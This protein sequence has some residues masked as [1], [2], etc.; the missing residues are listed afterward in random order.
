[1]NSK[2]IFARLLANENITIIHGNGEYAMFNTN[3]RVLTLPLWNDME[4]YDLLLGHEVGHALYTPANAWY[5]ALTTN[6]TVPKDIFNIVEDVRIERLIQDKYPGLVSSFKRGYKHMMSKDMFRLAGETHLTVQKYSFLDRMNIKAK[7]RDLVTVD[8]L[9]EELVFVERAN[10][11]ETFDEVIELSKDI[12]EHVKLV[13]QKIAVEAVKEMEENSRAEILEQSD[14]EDG[15]QETLSSGN[16]SAGEM[17]V[18]QPAE[19]SEDNE[20]QKQKNNPE[21][22]GKT[23]YIH[24]EQNHGG[25]ITDPKDLPDQYKSLTLDAFEVNK[26]NFVEKD[27]KGNNKIICQGISPEQMKEMI[28]PY[29]T[30]AAQRKVKGNQKMTVQFINDNKNAVANMIKEFELRKAAYQF[31]KATISKTGTLDV[32]KLHSYKTSEDLFL[33]SM[34]LGEFKDHGMVMLVDYSGSMRATLKSVIKQVLILATF[35]KKTNIPFEIYGFTKTLWG[36]NYYLNNNPKSAH[37]EDHVNTNG[38]KIF[39]L[40]SSSFDKTTYREAF[41]SL[42]EQCHIRNTHNYRDAWYVDDGLETLG[43]TPL[44]ESIMVMHDVL[45]KFKTKYNSQKVIFVTLTDGSAT[46]LTFNNSYNRVSLKIKVADKFYDYQASEFTGTLVKSLKEQ[47]LCDK[48]L[49]YSLIEH[50]SY[51]TSFYQRYVNQQATSKNLSMEV[52]RKKFRADGMMSFDN[53]EGYDRV[54]MLRQH[55]DFLNDEDEMEITSASTKSQIAK[56]FKKHAVSKKNS[57][58]VAIKFA[59]TIS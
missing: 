59:E 45:R 7:L 50:A 30:L 31:K 44:N 53:I 23:G 26:K 37:K 48:T 10:R 18:S 46:Y 32:D 49:S 52:A 25:G 19:K 4:V 16:I 35:C 28:I 42:V 43:D 36:Y 1:M 39:E 38:I 11:A 58:V 3:T 51:F 56:Q 29:S 33:R 6:S 2:H 5:D 17:D 20:K 41:D 13:N 22:S 34:K 14:D 27:S 55:N 40:L 47:G 54:I 12:C 21:S 24:H 9:P 8:F 15:F 57:R